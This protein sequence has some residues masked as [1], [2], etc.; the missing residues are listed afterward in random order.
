MNKPATPPKS[1][2]APRAVQHCMTAEQFDKHL[3]P[4]MGR[5]VGSKRA[6][7]L[8]LVLVDGLTAYAAAKQ[9]QMD[10]ASI[11]HA[12]EEAREAMEH[13]TALQYPAVRMPPRRTKPASASN[14]APE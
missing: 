13:V 4:L 7:G 1:P 2:G 3:M 11:T 10:S 5:H 6:Q 12:V 14:P 9:L 8:R